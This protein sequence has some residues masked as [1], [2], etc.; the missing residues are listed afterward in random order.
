MKIR[1]VR[2][3]RAGLVSLLAAA[4][5][6]GTPGCIDNAKS[7]VIVAAVPLVASEDSCA[8][9]VQDEESFLYQPSGLL[10]LNYPGFGGQP[11]YFLHVQVHNY[12]LNNSSD[13]NQTINANDVQLES[14]EVRF[15]W[16]MGRELLE[17]A[18]T[19]PAGQGLLLIED[20]KVEIPTSG[21]VGAAADT[22][23]PGQTIAQVLAIPPALVGSTLTTMTESYVDSLV[24]GA[25]I[26]VIGKTLGGSRIES[27]EFV[28]PIYFCWG[29][30]QCPSGMTYA[31]CLGGQDGFSCIP[32]DD[33]TP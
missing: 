14:F 33:T 11:R 21:I 9:Q 28:Y 10:D 6:A 2:V 26:K 25:R 15:K 12:M 7:L 13:E 1:N 5:L 8:A 27:N 3:I 20:Q 31:A 29:C 17:D 19:F 24:L 18:A 16:L 32:P 4:L 23:S 22:G 30:H